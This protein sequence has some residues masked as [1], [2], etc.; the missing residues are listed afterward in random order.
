MILYKIFASFADGL[1]SFLR[2][3][4]PA[5]A[6]YGKVML[7]KQ[8]RAVKCQCYNIEFIIAANSFWLAHIIAYTAGYASKRLK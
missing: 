4:H 1:V 5:L 7:Y 8:F 3:T 2:E 6:A